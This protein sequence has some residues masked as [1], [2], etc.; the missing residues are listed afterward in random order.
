MPTCTFSNGQLRFQLQPGQYA[1]I[2]VTFN[3]TIIRHVEVRSVST[4]GVMEKEWTSCPYNGTNPEPVQNGHSS[5]YTTATAVAL[6]DYFIRPVCNNLPCQP[7]N[8]GVADTEFA[9]AQAQELVDGTWRFT[10]DSGGNPQ[11]I[12]VIV[13][14]NNI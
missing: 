14:V 4:S 10:L 3:G 6:I 5:R 8:P 1:I 7:N 9:D 2:T 11:T 13:A 12:D